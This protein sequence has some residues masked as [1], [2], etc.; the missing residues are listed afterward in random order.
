[1]AARLARAPIPWRD[2]ATALVILAMVAGFSWM[3]W[4]RQPTAGPRTHAAA[5][6]VKLTY[7]PAYKSRAPSGS[8]EVAFTDGRHRFVSMLWSEVYRCKAGDAVDVIAV[9]AH[10]GDPELA[11]D[12]RTCGQAE[13]HAQR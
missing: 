12:A 13:R 10:V 5:R 4:A 9:P 8:V 3:M 7:V 1:M 2:V 11:I 6:I